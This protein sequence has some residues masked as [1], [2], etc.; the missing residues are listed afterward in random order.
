MVLSRLSLLLILAA[1]PQQQ[2]S[3]VLEETD[4]VHEETRRYDSYSITVEPMQQV[5]VRMTSE[6]F[7]TYLI[8]RSPSGRTFVNDDHEGTSVSQVDFVASEGGEWEV[9]AS[10][11]TMEQGGAYTVD[12]TLGG[13]AEMETF[14]GRLDPNDAEALKGEYY[15]TH[16]IEIADET[17]FT[18]ELTAFGFDG[19][20]VAYS[21]DGQVWRND[22]AGDTSISRI[23]PI[24]GAGSWTVHVTTS[25]AGQVGAYD[26]NVIKLR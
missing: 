25:F 20:L 1:L 18:L 16:T 22:D 7:D 10:A 4:P 11:F 3:G 26:L 13:I 2:F 9:L 19:Y 24:S 8:V 23:G 6:E 14:S 17:P 15:D 12:V 21:P 5:T